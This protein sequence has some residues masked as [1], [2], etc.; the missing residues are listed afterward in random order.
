M[1][2]PWSFVQHTAERVAIIASGPSLQRLILQVPDNITVITVNAAIAYGGRSDFWFTMD[3]S[4]ANQKIM[5][6]A[7]RR[8]KTV[9]YA[10]VID[11]YGS[12]HAVDPVQRVS[13][14]PCVHYLR[15]FEGPGPMLSAYG[16]SMNPTGLSAGNSA[17]G[18]LGLAFLMGARK[19]ALL[20]VDATSYGYSYGSGHPVNLR[21]LPELFA[22]TV[23]QLKGANVEVVNGSPISRVTCFRRI[24]PQPA[25]NWLAA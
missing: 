24:F 7:C 10:C 1:S 25:L 12:P 3:T 4:K 20:G 14:Q 22:S 16:L 19:I 9:F 6:T 5:G 21:H 11:Q 13:P 18:A 23:E 17:Y 8:A 2:P 15:R